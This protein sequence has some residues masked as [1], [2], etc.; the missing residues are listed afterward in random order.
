MGPKRQITATA[1]FPGWKTLLK[2]ETK[3]KLK[4]IHTAEE[5]EALLA[6]IRYGA[7]NKGIEKGSAAGDK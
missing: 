6:R 7:Q 4:P 3:M 5:Q 2:I 1:P